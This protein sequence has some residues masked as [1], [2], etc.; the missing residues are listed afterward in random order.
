MYVSARPEI[1]KIDMKRI[2]IIG[3]ASI[4]RFSVAY[5][6]YSKFQGG[7]RKILPFSLMLTVSDS[8]DMK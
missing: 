2:G 8:S 3:I 7:G 4:P 6:C 1:N 5:D